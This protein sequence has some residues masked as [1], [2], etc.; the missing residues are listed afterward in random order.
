MKCRRSLFR[1]H[2]VFY[3]VTVLTALVLKLH[4]SRASP[5]DLGW[6][7]GPTADLVSLMTGETFAFEA[8][9][10]YVCAARGV[11]IAPACAGVNFMLMAFGMAAFT[12]LR[13]L[14][15]RRQALVWLAFSLSAAYILT[16]GVNAMRVAASLLTLE[17]VIPGRGMSWE[18]AHLLEGVVIYFF[19][20]YLFYSMI[21]KMITRL[22]ARQPAQALAP[23]PG[24]R[25]WKGHAAKIV[26]IGAV[27]CA[28]YLG[29]TV[30]VPFLNNAAGK[31]G[32]RF[33]DHAA[34]VSGLCLTTWLCLAVVQYC[35]RRAG[36]IFKG[37]L[38]KHE[39]EGP[40]R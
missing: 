18:R 38:G 19:F 9:C 35:G 15:R 1:H 4:Y 30:V 25:E 31:F 10:G 11:I 34:M 23:L 8:G 3:L 17:K 24:R 26:M 16:L 39:T 21:L 14:R 22:T 13:H 40:D 36:L 27:P 29:G 20:Q 32:G 5:V 12:G 6:I 33:F 2:I 37:G 28:W 7:L